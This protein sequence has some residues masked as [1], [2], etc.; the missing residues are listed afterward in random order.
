MPTHQLRQ[1]F[2]LS[3]VDVLDAPTRCADNSFELVNGPLTSGLSGTA[4]GPQC[5]AASEP[6]VGLSSARYALTGLI[7]M[8]D[9]ER[10]G[11]L[12]AS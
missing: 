2:V 11:G 7:R 12:A 10:P 1:R 5:S 3:T 9:S 4:L 6:V 8:P